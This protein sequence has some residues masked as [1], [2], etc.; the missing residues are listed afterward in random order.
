MKYVCKCVCV[1]IYILTYVYLRPKPLTSW[2]VK[3]RELPSYAQLLYDIIVPSKSRAYDR[4]PLTG[5]PQ[6]NLLCESLIHSQNHQITEYLI[7]RT[8]FCLVLVFRIFD[9]YKIK[10]S[11]RSLKCCNNLGAHLK[12]KKKKRKKW[13]G[14]IALWGS[15]NIHIRIPECFYFASKDHNLNK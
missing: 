5:N 14:K 9:L 3:E 13:A 10:H 15:I 11:W 7:L 6:S 12:K 4:S 2:A 1:Y 8:C